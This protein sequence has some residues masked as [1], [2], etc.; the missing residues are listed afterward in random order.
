[1]LYLVGL[2]LWDEKDITLRGLEL[3]RKADQVYFES[4]TDL[5]GGTTKEKLE[6]EI[7]F[8]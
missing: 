2:G 1:M 7:Y 8:I 5:L 6:K 3:A 4:Y